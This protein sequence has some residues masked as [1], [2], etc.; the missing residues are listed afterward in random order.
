MGWGLMSTSDGSQALV[1]EADRLDSL[2]KALRK[3]GYKTIGPKARDGAVVLEEISGA[4]ELPIGLVDDQQPGAYRLSKAKKPAY[5]DFTHGSQTW[6]RYLFP[7][8]EKL[9]TAQKTDNGFV[10][11][12]EVDAPKYA[13]IGVRACELAA[14][15][16]QDKV[17]VDGE[18]TATGYKA[19]RDK[20]LII[21]LNCRRAGGTCF[22]T[23]MNT[24]PKV[25]DGYD[26]AL[27][28]LTKKDSHVFL[29]EAGSDQGE[30][31]LARLDGR[32]AVADDFKA[33]KKAVSKAAKSMGRDMLPDAAKI[34]ADNLE[35]P[36]WQDIAK[37]CL[38]CANCT[39]VCPTCF[40]NTTSDT[41][42]LDGQTAERWRQWDSCFTLD[43]SYIHGGAIR[44]DGA[45]RYRQWMTHKLSTWHDQFGVSGCVGCGRCITWCPVGI[46]ITAEVRAMAPKANET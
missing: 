14:I 45:Q 15:Q 10:V 3:S 16:I 35:S 25:K 4:D 17:F 2:I 34:L 13:F 19:R 20:A 42:S 46:D 12:A 18:H 36:R 29:V 37:R 9:W 11:E 44:R 21:A 26:L 41:T 23:S 24:G 7:P 6:K 1:I 43:F 28:E 40:C 30:K 27:T 39:L 22:C 5:F 33:A 32:P 38:D 8:K 31:I